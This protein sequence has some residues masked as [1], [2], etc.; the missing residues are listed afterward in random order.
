M[1]VHQH[2]RVH[3]V[4]LAQGRTIAALALQLFSQL[5]EAR[6]YETIDLLS[7]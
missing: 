1:A 3:P 2:E 6:S 4:L 7:S 5:E